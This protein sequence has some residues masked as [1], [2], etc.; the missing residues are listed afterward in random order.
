MSKRSIWRLI[1]VLMICGICAYFFLPLQKI[2]LGLDLRGGVRFDLEVQ[3]HEA[4]EADFRDTRDRLV[5]R[6]QEKGIPAPVVK[7]QGQAIR[8]EGYNAD[9]KGI[10][11]KV[12]KT[13]QGYNTSFDA[14][15]VSLTHTKFM[16][17]G[18]K[19]EA[20]QRALQIIEN[21]VNQF[22]MT[23]PEITAS[24]E[25]G[26][27]IVVEL[28]GI[29]DAEKDR[30][31][32]LLSTPGRL[33]QR[34]V[35]KNDPT[36]GGGW[37]TREAALAQFNGQLPLGTELLPEMEGEREVRHKGNQTV[38]KG[39]KDEKVKR[40]ILLEE[41]VY[42]DGA[43]I[44]SAY[45][46]VDQNTN[47]P[48]I[49]YT[50]NSKG[51]DEFLTLSRIAAEEK[52]MI[53]ILLDR[54]V[55]SVLRCDQPIPGGAVRISGQFTPEEAEDFARKLKSGA[56]RASI[57][58]LE[59]KTVGPTLGADS[60]RT[61][62]L[63]SVIGYAFIIIFM[64]VYYKWSGVNALVALTVNAIVM[65]GLLGSFRAVFTLPGIAGFILSLGMAVDA[66]ILIFERIREELGLGKS[67]HA[68]V[69]AGFD[70]VFWTIVDSHVTQLFSALLLYTFGTGPVKGF[71]VTLTV[72]VVASLFTSIYIS[73]Y[74][75]DWV[76]ERNPGTKTLSI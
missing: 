43:D 33:E 38:I 69:H 41:K 8:V 60:I 47:R 20:G 5:D 13:F 39:K 15:G 17:D 31:R 18:L 24:G 27:R 52:R 35:A 30:I 56:M 40:W 2:R 63:A 46:S 65:M 73:R 26:S 32:D 25:D 44:V 36:G 10:V 12:L 16:A 23:E 67:V 57:K 64:I 3:S 19:K 68:A 42:V 74:I 62:V 58:F 75:Y 48:E 54:K 71:A 11:D 72:G 66:N 61:G 50:L 55:V 34:L 9:Q 76:L 70:R 21:R 49:S 6:L 28:P 7:I 51:A 45:P 4:L 59:E 29:S 14:Q 22:G 53:G 37:P 1:S